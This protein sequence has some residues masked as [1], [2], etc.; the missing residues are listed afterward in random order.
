MKWARKAGAFLTPRSSDK[1]LAETKGEF[2]NND[3]AKLLKDKDY[4]KYAET[5]ERLGG[6]K[7][8]RN[9]GEMLQLA[10]GQKGSPEDI[11]NAKEILTTLGID[12]S[13]PDAEQRL[14]AALDW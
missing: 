9:V 3:K 4:K 14:K 2:A 7:K 5:E 6:S 13:T 12:A 8:S 11:A 10:R 1:M